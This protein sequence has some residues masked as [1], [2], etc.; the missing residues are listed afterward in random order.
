MRVKKKDHLTVQKKAK[1]VGMA[2]GGTATSQIS[3]T[4]NIPR[5]TA[6]SVLEQ[7]KAQ[8]TDKQAK[9]SDR[10]MKT[11]NRDH[12]ELKQLLETNRK[13]KLSDITDMMTTKISTR[14]A[15]KRIRDLGYSNRVA[16]KKPFVNE[17]QAK[18]RLAFA[19]EHLNWTVADWNQV[20]WS[21]ESSF[22]IGKSSQPDLV[23]QTRSEKFR[24]DCLQGTFKSGRTSTMVWGVFFSTTKLPLVFLPPK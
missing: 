12:Q 14:T 17:I 11:T 5:S 18:K 24:A 19:R 22:K 9:G 8:D 1:I 7:N 6:Q 13:T 3:H 16:V 21:D 2:D 4:Y 10:P 15:R 20:I 23:W